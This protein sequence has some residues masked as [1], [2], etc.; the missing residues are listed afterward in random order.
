[1]RKPRGDIN[2]LYTTSDRQNNDLSKWIAAEN[3]FHPKLAKVS[4]T[5]NVMPLT[6]KLIV[7]DNASPRVDHLIDR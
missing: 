1:M 3:A 5:L 7:K 2:S 4:A 6:I